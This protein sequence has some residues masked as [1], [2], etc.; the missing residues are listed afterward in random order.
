MFYIN[1]LGFSLFKNIHKFHGFRKTTNIY[2]ISIR[3]CLLY[4]VFCVKLDNHSILA[5]NEEIPSGINPSQYQETPSM[6]QQ[7]TYNVLFVMSFIFILLKLGAIGNTKE[8]LFPFSDEIKFH[9]PSEFV[10]Q[11]DIHQQ[12]VNQETMNQASEEINH[13]S[14]SIPHSHDEHG[15]GIRESF[16]AE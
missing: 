2:F 9:D 14:E 5:Q 16:D 15:H 12:D 11:G 1:M 8:C 6:G 4:F 7:G 3:V 10:L 13:S